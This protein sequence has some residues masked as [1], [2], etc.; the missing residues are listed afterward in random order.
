MTTFE[1]GKALTEGLASVIRGKEQTLELFTAAFLAG[2]HVLVNDAPGLGKT[3]LAK[4]LARLVGNPGTG[5]G[6]AEFRRI[7]FTPDLLPYDITGVDVFNP[8]DQ[9]F[10]F[11][12]GPV[13]CDILLADEINRTTPKVQSALL[14][15]MAERQV[16]ANGTTRA[17]SPVFFVAATQNPVES[18]GT[19]P[20][21]AAQL[22]RFM[23]Q[24]SLGYPDEESEREILHEDPAETALPKVKPVVSRTEIIAS[25]SEQNGVYCHPELEKTI[26]AIVRQTRTH[27]ALRLGVSP[28]GALSLLHA[29]R[30][31]ALIRGRDWIEDADV[32][33]LAAPVLA[34]R[35]I[36]R[37]QRAEPAAVITE[38]AKSSLKR[39]LRVTDWARE[40]R[41]YE[42]KD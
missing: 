3:T 32:F 35:V 11:I 42:R 26:V 13:F 38:I 16:T 7:Q 20:L 30:A 34:H 39:M 6:S 36:S 18:V 8:R 41:P 23:M 4:T 25:R 31:L 5:E 40:P 33:A 37:E 21:P 29:A 22:D 14:E 15:V 17:V 19:Y 2:G 12:E 24:L 28:R 27:Q 10:E 1:A 9:R